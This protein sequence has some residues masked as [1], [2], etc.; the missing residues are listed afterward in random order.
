MIIG[1]VAGTVV[2]SQK[3]PRLEGVKLLLI[4]Q[5]DIHGKPKGSFVVAVDSVD[6]GV[7]ELVLCASGSS[8]RQT[9]S[10]KDKPVDTV[11]MAIIDQIHTSGD[12]TY[13]KG[14]ND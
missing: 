10:T 9:E 11:V 8:A 6:A 14:K 2:S 7:G 3:E 12:P 4:E 1:R 13:T 5:T